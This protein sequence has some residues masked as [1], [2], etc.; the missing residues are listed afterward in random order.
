MVSGA[1]AGLGAQGS[2]ASA[3]H[4]VRIFDYLHRTLPASQDLAGTALAPKAHGTVEL[5][6]PSWPTRTTDQANNLDM[7]A[8]L[9]DLPPAWQFGPEYLT[10]VLWAINREGRSVNLAEIQVQGGSGATLVAP[11]GKRKVTTNLKAFGLVVTA[12]PYF[13]VTTPSEIVVMENAAKPET[14]GASGASEAK[15][16]PLPRA[17]YRIGVSPQPVY[18]AQADTGLPF[19]LLEARNAVRIA[20]WAGA[21]RYAPESFGV[22]MLLLRQA[23]SEQA[24]K[25]PDRQSHWA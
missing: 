20:Q 9:R 16:D 17:H 18:N 22:A 21:D 5:A 4:S 24:N 1:G 2:A 11:S 15:Y 6:R 23:E 10:Y 8:V 3:I 25:D 7:S 19:E 12:E 14:D 13:A